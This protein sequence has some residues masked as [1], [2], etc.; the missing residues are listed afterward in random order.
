MKAL[1][2]IYADWE[3]LLEKVHSCQK[4]R[5]KSYTE[6]KEL[7]IHLLVTFVYKLLL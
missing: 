4:N 1:F 6:K 2:L 3:F 7:S 5:E